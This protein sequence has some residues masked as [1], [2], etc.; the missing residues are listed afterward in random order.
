MAP[1]LATTDVRGGALR[2]LTTGLYVLTTCVEDM[3]HSATIAW[4]SQVSA[5]PTLVM[6]A[7]RRNSHLAQSVRQAHRFAL[8]ILAAEQAALAAQFFVHHAEPAA[9]STISGFGFRPGMGHCPL[10]TDAMAWLEC[11]VAAELPSP[12]DHVLV[13]GEVTGAGMRHQGQPMVLWATP[14]SYG[15]TTG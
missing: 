5:E 4:V 11:R 3:I 7:L 1:E 15:G 2:L 12:G 8:N 14:W 6:V 9:T 10:L 13:L